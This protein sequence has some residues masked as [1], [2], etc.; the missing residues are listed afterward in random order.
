MISKC[1]EEE[2]RE[3]ELEYIKGNYPREMFLHLLNS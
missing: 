1:I 3:S 2:E